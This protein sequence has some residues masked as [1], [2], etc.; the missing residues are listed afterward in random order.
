MQDCLQNA[1]V[2][3]LANSF[4]MDIAEAPY[5]LF[6][7]VR[8]LYSN[9]C[10]MQPKNEHKFMHDNTTTAKRKKYTLYVLLKQIKKST[11]ARQ[12]RTRRHANIEHVGPTLAVRRVLHVVHPTNPPT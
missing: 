6:S 3:F 2:F 10:K 7:L 4:C 9:K 8:N 11:S 12:R 1:V 5:I